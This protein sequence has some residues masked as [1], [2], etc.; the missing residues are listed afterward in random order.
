[1]PP[2][3]DAAAA[4]AGGAPARP[5]GLLTYS[6]SNLGDDIQSLAALR[7]LPG[8]SVLLDR[9]TFA[10][11]D[12]PA[13][14]AV[15][16]NGWWLHRPRLLARGA[17]DLDPMLVSIHIHPPALPMLEDPRVRAFLLRHGPVGCR[18]LA[19]LAALE[20]AGIPARFTGCLTLT[21]R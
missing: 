3:A 14:A 18:D 15:I 1:M 7:F 16:L 12:P 21:L 5:W 4:A 9:D 19:T 6:T 13:S 17:C 8:A 2:P 20:R 10:A 11:S